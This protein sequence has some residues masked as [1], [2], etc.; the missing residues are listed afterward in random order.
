MTWYAKVACV[1]LL[2]FAWYLTTCMIVGLEYY[3]L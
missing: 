1:T 3:Y 2:V